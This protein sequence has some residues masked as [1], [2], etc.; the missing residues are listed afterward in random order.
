MRALISN[1]RT[2]FLLFFSIA[3]GATTVLFWH[4]HAR[5][6]ST[7]DAYLRTHILAVSSELSG[8]V[9][10]LP[11]QDH[12]QVAAGQLLFALDPEPYQIALKQA[13]AKWQLAKQRFSAGQKSLA[14]EDK[15]LKN[16]KSQL[17]LAKK[18]AERAH[19]LYEKKLLSTAQRDKTDAQLT[20]AKLALDAEQETFAA[21]AIQ[22]ESQ[23]EAAPEVKLA[24]AAREQAE[25]QLNHT[26]IYAPMAGHIQR[27]TLRPGSWVNAGQPQFMIVAQDNW[28]I[29][30]NFKEGKLTHIKPGQPATIRVDLYP[31]HV[32]KGVV[33]AVGQ[34]TTAAFSI[35]P[36]ENASGNWVKVSQR[37]PVKIEVLNPDKRFPLRYGASC[38]VTID[39]AR[40]NA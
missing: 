14:A 5:H 6:P 37:F 19:A 25:R 20:T 7:S 16:R 24:L 8:P 3:L 2:P 15:Q 27:L 33:K 26:Q 29:E 28:W 17:H 38:T 32:F 9:S 18:Q 11:V 40:N 21:L 10:Q 36:P 30:A 23:H 34:S 31:N 22:Y 12:Q 4:Y 13:T 35:L 39:T 1:Y